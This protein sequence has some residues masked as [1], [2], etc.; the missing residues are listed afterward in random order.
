ML[1][2]FKNWDTNCK[3][4]Q[5][6]EVQDHVLYSGCNRFTYEGKEYSI[7]FGSTDHRR[8]SIRIDRQLLG[9]IYLHNGKM[10]IYEDSILSRKRLEN[11][12]NKYNMDEKIRQAHAQSMIAKQEMKIA[13][14]VE[15]KHELE[16]AIENIK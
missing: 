9:A 13:K 16:L 3:L 6:V 1:Y 14:E 10:E 12:I 7:E 11:F 8:L 15:R 4:A 2:Q 5:M